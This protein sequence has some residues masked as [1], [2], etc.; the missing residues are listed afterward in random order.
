LII[1][2]DGAS[3][4]ISVPPEASRKGLLDSLHS[5]LLSGGRSVVSYRLNGLGV[6]AEAVVSRMDQGLKAEDVLDLITEP[7]GDVITRQLEEMSKAMI[8]CEDGLL[9]IGEGLTQEDPSES[10][11][12]LSSL[13][14]D[15]KGMAETLGKVIQLF[16]IEDGADGKMASALGQLSS[17]FQRIEEGFHKGE[18]MA[19]ADYFEHDFPGVLLKIRGILPDIATQVR[20]G[21]KTA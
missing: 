10:L 5:V 21:L 3:D 14:L 11:E 1:H 13:L 6:E 9:Q 17:A 12:K 16:S 7:L 4:L 18:V 19:L 20:A 2:I 8:V 15:L